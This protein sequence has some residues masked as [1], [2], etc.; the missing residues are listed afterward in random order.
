MRIGQKLG[1][2]IDPSVYE[3]E[4]SINAEFANLLKKGNIVRLHNFEKTREYE[5]KVIRINGRVDQSTQT[6]NI[7]IEVKGDGLKEGMFLE[8]N[9]PAREVEDAYRLSRKL[10]VD[11]KAVYT[12]EDNKLKM[13]EV[14]IVHF[15]ENSAVVKGLEND[16]KILSK[17]IP[18]AFDGMIVKTFN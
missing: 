7:Y 2:F 10:L 1:E 9:V 16:T 14:T 17:M 13:I 5:G 11:N 8:A 4:V 3:M 12:V 6:V 18:G 15:D